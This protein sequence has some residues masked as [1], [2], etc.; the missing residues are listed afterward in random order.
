MRGSTPRS[1]P[2]RLFIDT[3]GWLV[4][5]DQRDPSHSAAVA[6]RRKRT[7]RASLVTT[8]YV[9][10]ETFT[11]VFSRG[12][13]SVARQFGD[14]ILEAQSSGLLA[15]EPITPARFR[16]AYRMRLRYHDKPTI[17]FTDFSSF[18]V[19]KELDIRDVLT[20]DAHFAQVQSGFRLRP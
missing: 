18:V 6:E 2:S 7:L 12:A 10:D 19:M 4:L 11:R 15:V 1:E 17:S 13:F 20:A 5:A 16:S 9:L 3:W 8:D 14:A